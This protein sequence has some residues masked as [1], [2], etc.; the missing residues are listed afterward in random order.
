M[1][2]F[3]KGM[4]VEVIDKNKPSR[5]RV[6]KIVENT[7]GRLRLKYDDLTNDEEFHCHAH[8][9]LIHPVGWSVSVAHEISATQGNNQS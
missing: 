9:P 5:M 2:K 8:S 1:E 4:R 7:G 3:R 6:A